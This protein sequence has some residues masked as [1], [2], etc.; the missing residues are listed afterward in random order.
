M[1]FAKALSISHDLMK[2]HPKNGNEL[3]NYSGISNANF[4]LLFSFTGTD[5]VE[6]L[7]TMN[8]GQW[9]KVVL[10]EW[11]R[12]E[13]ILC[14]RLGQKNTHLARYVWSELTLKLC[15]C[16]SVFNTFLSSSDFAERHMSKIANTANRNWVTSNAHLPLT[17]TISHAAVP[18]KKIHT[19]F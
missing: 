13:R 12:Y 1:S 10:E 14:E 2:R 9:W 5:S 19:I 16:K 3:N 6:S 8:S 4:F 7:E 11:E 15:D 18:Q 17:R